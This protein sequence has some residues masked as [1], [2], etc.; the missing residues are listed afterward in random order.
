VTIASRPCVVRDGEGYEVIWVAKGTDLF[1]Q[2]G[3]DRKSGDLPVRQSAR[4]NVAADAV[5][6]APKRPLRKASRTRQSV[7]RKSMPSGNDPM[8]GNR[9]SLVTNA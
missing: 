3:L 8:G 9:F 1:L 7:I 2:M 4:E 6:I 5:I